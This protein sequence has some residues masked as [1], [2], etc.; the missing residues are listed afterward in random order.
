MNLPSFSLTALTLFCCFLFL[1]PAY[2]TSNP[3]TNPD[4]LRQ[5]LGHCQPIVVA[6][7]NCITHTIELS[8]FVEWVFTGVREPINALWTTGQ[9]GHKIT[10]VPPGTWSWD[11]TVTSCEI[12]HW[13]T[14][15]TNT[16]TFFLGNLE[17]QGATTIC[18]GNVGEL[19]VES[20]GYNFPSYIW[21]PA[22]PGGTLSP[23]E[24][25]AQ[26]TYALSVTDDLGCPFSD[27]VT[28]DSSGILITAAEQ[29]FCPGDSIIIGGVV[30]NHSAIVTDTIPSTT[31][32]CD[33]LVIYT[34][35]FLDYQ[36]RS[37]N[38]TFCS[39]S[40]VTIGGQVYTQPGAVI[41]TIA[42]LNGCD[43]I[44]TYILQFLNTSAVSIN[45]PSAITVNQPNGGGAAVNYSLPTAM[46]NC[47]CPG[48]GLAMTSGLPSGSNF[49]Q[50]ISTVCYAA[51]D[52]CGQS[53]TC[54]FNVTITGAVDDPCDIKVNGCI[55]YELLSIKA[56]LG[57]NR[58]YRIRVTNNCPNK[59]LYTS[60]EVPSGIVA[61]AP[62]H[63]STYTAPS[64]NTYLVRSPSFSSQYSIRFKSV[65]HNI[66]NGESDIFE[67]TLPAQAQVTFIHVVSGLEY[68]TYLEAHL[69]TFNC[70]IEIVPNGKRPS[71]DRKDPFLIEATTA[72]KLLLFPNPTSQQVQVET[73]GQSGALILQDATGRIVLRQHLDGQPASCSLS[74]L[75]AGIYQAVFTGEK[76]MLYGTL[77]VQY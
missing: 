6:D 7:T 40:S 71:E 43:T 38:I 4:S 28:V 49:P 65:S 29:F 8:A 60:M 14:D 45:C 26:G 9:T 59:L 12:N 23:F 1:K 37:E 67:F 69:N 46:T 41:D 25:T 32:G 44:V 3:L 22:N 74:G 21:A 24:I 15:Y 33:T 48:L 58:T 31:M 52:S 13:H 56:D 2:S 42:S 72:T 16:G 51:R 27:Q 11:P 61:I 68:N 53:A 50:G 66:I 35:T 20:G 63:G 18:A 75:P 17:I 76:T 64:G 10:V 19:I 62:A 73:G 30:Y 54:C 55:K 70:P 39:G 36:I 57:G 34:L 47:P 77:V 5:I